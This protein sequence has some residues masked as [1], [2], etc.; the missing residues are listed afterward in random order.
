MHTLVLYESGE[1]IQSLQDIGLGALYL[2]EKECL[3]FYMYIQLNPPVMQF[4]VVQ[5]L[6]LNFTSLQKGK[7]EAT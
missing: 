4:D 5:K 1:L 2:F 3:V 7:S 6:L